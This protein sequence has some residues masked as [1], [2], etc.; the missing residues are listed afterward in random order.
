MGWCARRHHDRQRARE[1]GC[2]PALRQV[3]NR[4]AGILHGCLDTRTT[5]SEAT[6]WSHH[7]HTPAA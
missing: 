6:A 3:G 4:L 7:A 1:T 2:N 5:H